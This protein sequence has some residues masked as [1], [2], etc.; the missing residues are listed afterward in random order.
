MIRGYS[1]IEGFWEALG[2]GWSTAS[3]VCLLWRNV[4]HA[5]FNLGARK[6]AKIIPM[7]C[8]TRT[9]DASNMH[10]NNPRSSNNPQLRKIP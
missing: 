1:L 10:R 2:L 5:G 6:I 4:G 8:M 7:V 3:R 9:D